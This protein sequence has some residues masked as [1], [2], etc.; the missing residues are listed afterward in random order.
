MGIQSTQKM[1]RSS[2]IERITKI[3]R[4]IEYKDYLG[5]ESCTFEQDISIKDFVNDGVC[6]DIDGIE[7]WTNEM[8]GD[9]LDQP[10]FRLSLFDNYEVLS[11]DDYDD[12]EFGW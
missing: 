11:D 4:L 1:S 12:E 5:I 3:V 2:A 9:Q 8:L 6:V 7:K 10:F